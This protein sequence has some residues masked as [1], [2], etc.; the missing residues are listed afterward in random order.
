MIEVRNLQKQFGAVAAL[1]DV[2][3]L[4]PD[5]A[6]TGLLG[7][8]GAGKSTT[9]RAIGGVL[10]PGGG[11][12]RIDGAWVSGGPA[13]DPLVLQRHVGGLLDHAGL[14]ARLT[15]RETFT[16]SGR[17]HGIPW[18][19]LRERVEE[20][21]AFLGMQPIA[22]RRTGGF[23]QGE[24][25]KTALG[26]ALIH[27]PKNLLL[28]EPTNGLDVP[29]IRALRLLLQRTRNAGACIVFSS[30]VLEEVRALCDR[31]VVLAQ[32]IVVAQGT[33]AELCRRARVRTLEDAFVS[34]TGTAEGL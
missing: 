24:R 20:V 13:D 10:K 9:L 6:I 34:F 5:S 21:I 22:D 23:S 33:P 15:P 18:R 14:Y 12:I 32:G 11:E 31:V 19:R 27:S 2:S 8:N 30:H 29:S 17:L 28:D 26:R 7:A 4:A 16:F 3:F 25:M 1:R